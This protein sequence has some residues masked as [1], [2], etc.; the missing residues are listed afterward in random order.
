ML[1]RKI[2][3]IQKSIR[4]WTYRQKFQRMKTCCVTIQSFWRAFIQQKRYR[5]VSRQ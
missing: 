1:T 2:V 3:T 5:A 4:G